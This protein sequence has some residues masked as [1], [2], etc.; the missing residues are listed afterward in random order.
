LELNG[1]HQFLVCADDVN[2]LGENINIIKRNTEGLSDAS[3]EV[4]M[5]V[6]TEKTKCMF[7]SRHQTTEQNHYWYTVVANR[8]FEN[9][10]KLKYLGMMLTNQNYIREKIRNRLNSGN[11]C[12][13]AVQNRLS[14][15]LISK[16]SN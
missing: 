1:T 14:F 8:S 11:A 16:K 7:M 10:A 3:K 6:N 13:H 5:E 4:G 12:Y 9:A 2:L 15:H